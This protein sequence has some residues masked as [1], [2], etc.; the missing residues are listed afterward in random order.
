VKKGPPKHG[1]AEPEADWRLGLRHGRAHYCRLIRIRHRQ[2]FWQQPDLRSFFEGSGAGLN[3]G[4]SVTFR[5]VPT[6]TVTDIQ[7]RFNRRTLNAR[8]PVYYEINQSRINGFGNPLISIENRIND[9]IR[10]GL[11]TRLVQQNFVTAQLAIELVI[12]PNTPIN[13]TRRGPGI[14]QIPTIPSEF[15]AIK[16]RFEHCDWLNSYRRRHVPSN[17]STTCLHRPKQE[18]SG[19]S[20]YDLHAVQELA[21]DMRTELPPLFTEIKQ[22]SRSAQGACRTGRASLR[23]PEHEAAPLADCL[24]QPWIGPT[25]PF[26]RREPRL[27]RQTI[28]WPTPTHQ[29][30]QSTLSEIEA[31]VRSIHS[32]ADAIERNPIMLLRGYR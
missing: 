13:L 23:N 6:G 5:G 17:I 27:P 2:L 4:A 7:V 22:I 24:K 25:Q 15:E 20:E 19:N 1:Q 12:Q 28:C 26:G 21:N 14:P 18:S 32:L 9:A 10:S 8:I 29:N 11:R 31:A 16:S 30:L 3:I